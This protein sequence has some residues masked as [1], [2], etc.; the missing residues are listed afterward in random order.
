MVELDVVLNRINPT[1]DPAYGYKVNTSHGIF[2][3]PPQDM[4]VVT[5]QALKSP[6][7]AVIKV[8]AGV[9][10]ELRLIK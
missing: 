6:V 4:P 5:G 9:I 2:R 7:P 1:R 3:A 10:Q 8:E